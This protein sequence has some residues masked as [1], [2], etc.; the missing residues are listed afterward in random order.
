LAAAPVP[1]CGRSGPPLIAGARSTSWG[2][3]ASGRPSCAATCFPGVPGA[4]GAAHAPEVRLHRS[5][6][7]QFPAAAPPRPAPGPTCAAGT[8]GRA[9]AR[10]KLLGATAKGAHCRPCFWARAD[11]CERGRC[12]VPNTRPGAVCPAWP[13]FNW[14]PGTRCARGRLAATWGGPAAP[15][16]R[17]R[18]GDHRATTRTKG[19]AFTI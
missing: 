3:R 2:L 15:R 13:A 18:R 16:Q 4:R 10:A 9:G 17:F 6:R 7:G 5:C 12:A 19:R 1:P 11:R 8:A 14:L